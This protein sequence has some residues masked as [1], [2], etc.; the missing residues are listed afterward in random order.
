MPPTRLV[1]GAQW[2]L[3]RGCVERNVGSWS[4]IRASDRQSDPEDDSTV[5]ILESRILKMHFKV[6]RSDSIRY[7]YGIQL[8]I[9]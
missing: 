6:D 3:A 5:I 2:R 7:T 4:P 8:A 9:D 1:A